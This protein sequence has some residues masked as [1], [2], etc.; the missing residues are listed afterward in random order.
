MRLLAVACFLG[1]GVVAWFWL[2]GGRSGIGTTVGRLVPREARSL[3][4]VTL[5]TTRADRLQPYGAENVATPALLQLAK[6]GVLFESASSVAPI[7]LPAHTSI[8]TGQYPFHHGVRNNGSHY[9]SPDLTTLAEVLLGEGFRTAAFVSAAVLSRRYGLDQGFEIYDDDL[10]SG[11][12]RHP[13]MVPDRPADTT[14]AAA[15]TWLDTIAA[16]QRFFLWVHLYDPHAV[17]SPPPPYR[18]RY[19]DRLYDGEIAYMDSQIG[20]LLR[21]P[22]LAPESR[23]LV[24]AI[25]D[26][27]ESLGE[28]GEQTHGIFLYDA[29][30]RVPFLMRIP[31]GPPDLRI[32]SG[33]SQV[34]LVP[35]ALELLGLG[36]R[37]DLDGT[38]LVSLM[39]G[40]GHRARELYSEAH[41]PFYTYGWA[42][43]RALSNGRFKVIE[44]PRP[45]LFDLRRDPLELSNVAATNQG[46]L[47]DL[48]R[49]LGEW[50][51]E[52]DREARLELDVEAADQLRALGYLSA[53]STARSDAERLD[54]KDGIELHTGL[55]QARAFVHGGLWEPAIRQLRAVLTRDPHNLAAMAELAEA[56]QRT[57]AADE[58]IRVSEQALALDPSSTRLTLALAGLENG[59]GNRAKALELIDAA[60]NI[61]PRYVEARIQRIFQ[62]RMMKR[63]EEASRE[64][65]A[66]RQRHPQNPQ[67]A[68]AWVHAVALPE[69]RTEEAEAVL[70]DALVSD[71]FM[72]GCWRMLG[73]VLVA[74]GREEEA[75]EA[76]REALR[77]QPD[78]GDA[79]AL[80]GLALARHGAM[81]AP[82][83]LREAI[84]LID[85]FRPDLLVALG[86]WLAEHGRLE[87][88][89]AEYQ[90]VLEVDQS[91]ASARNNRA[92]ALYQTG[93]LAEA[94]SEL[95]DL[96]EKNP[97][98]ADAW[99]NLAAV[100]VD[101]GDWF[102]AEGASRQA[103][104][105]D[106]R[107]APSYNN[108]GLSLAG[109]AGHAAD[110]KA[111][112]LEALAIDE[113]YWQARLNLGL[114]EA[115]RGDSQAAASAFDRVVLEVPNQ[116]RAHF[117]LGRL[118]A[119]P[120]DDPVKARLHLNAFLRAMP[121]SA[122]GVAE[123]RRLVAELDRTRQIPAQGMTR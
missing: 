56:L 28:H 101:R 11:R 23:I 38:S 52:D 66:L 2:G 79:H 43:L 89:Q 100:L 102:A 19:R 67:V 10:S 22:R 81:D 27:G 53:P 63:S 17:Y 75:I 115:D 83:H 64:A 93:Q 21:H 29:T 14:V 57:G 94:E 92:I 45:E 85:E 73:Q 113:S 97:R 18:D 117:E 6:E 90:K 69:R 86:G 111:A 49:D 65:D 48:R 121:V 37:Q 46:V 60:I 105:L 40:L 109:Q 36:A 78:D 34:D 123:A 51:G 62:L 106:S 122:P 15:R 74:R 33:V 87:E 59:R 41:L 80:V 72:V 42:K 76:W 104:E 119:G 108:L 13:R 61:D 110:A 12:E 70:R 88:A 98:Y 8:L 96:V 32:G 30:I 9:A 82:H 114:V 50:V 16:S 112:F 20:E 95:R 25:G 120:L 3:L 44:A 116:P 31:G 55:E 91:H 103:I 39:E 4:L 7:T 84:R 77:H 26:H 35:T 47:H 118:Y 54:P 24:M 71:P 107:S 68:L 1:A 5:D 58:A 99:N